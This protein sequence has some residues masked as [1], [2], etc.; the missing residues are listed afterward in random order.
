MEKETKQK[1]TTYL[2]NGDIEGAISHLTEEGIGKSIEK[3]LIILLSRYNRLESEYRRGTLD[4]SIHNIETNKIIESLID[5]FEKKHS[6]ISFPVSNIQK[7]SDTQKIILIGFVNSGKTIYINRVFNDFLDKKIQNL[8]LEPGDEI[9]IERLDTMRMQMQYHGRFN[10]TLPTL[11]VAVYKANIFN[12]FGIKHKVEFLDYSGEQIEDL[13]IYKG[14]LPND[15]DLLEANI[16]YVVV[17]LL[18]HDKTID[19]HN[20]GGRPK[21]DEIANKLISSVQTFRN[22]KFA[23]GKSAGNTVALVFFKSDILHK[24]NVSEDFILKE[25]QPLIEFLKVR[26][27]NFDVFFVSSM[28]KGYNEWSRFS[29][30]SVN[31]TDLFIWSIKNST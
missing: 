29:L 6:N 19:F 27:S 10:F 25:Y 1:F 23:A 26:Y 14:W 18:Y 2:S 24:N 30:E 8:V 11:P 31:V 15:F 3:D 4:F 22:S 28:G 5:Y 16:L 12:D 21:A 17:D 13:L 9:T 20:F 7:K